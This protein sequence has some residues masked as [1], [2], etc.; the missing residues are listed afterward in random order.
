MGTERK[1]LKII[2]KLKDTFV[3]AKKNDSGIKKDKLV[4]EICMAHGVTKPKAIEYIQILIDGGFIVEDFY[5]LWLNEEPQV[6][7]ISREEAAH[8][9]ESNREVKS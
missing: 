3:Q 9:E 8:Q 2:N 1:R 7:E 5:G 4:Y 6:L